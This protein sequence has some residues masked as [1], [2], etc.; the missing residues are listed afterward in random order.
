[1]SVDNTNP[2]NTAAPVA[3]PVETPSTTEETLGT[4]PLVEAATSSEEKKEVEKEIK[5]AIRKLQLKVDGKEV[6]EELPF[7]LPDDPA[8]KEYMIRQLQLSK[9]SHQRANQ[10]STLDKE[11]RSFIQELRTDPEK[12]LSDPAFGVDLKEFAAKIIE[13]EIEQSKKS[14]E[15]VQREQLENELKKLQEERT[16]EKEELQQKQLELLQQQEYERYDR[17]MSDVLSKSDLPKS[18]YVVKKM[19]DYMLL[20]LESGKTDI[21]PSDV[22]PLVRDE[23]HKDIKDMFGIMP[24]EVIEQMIGKDTI[25]KLRKRSVARKDAP[26]PIAKAV[27]DVGHTATKKEA[28]KK[29]SYKEFF[30][31]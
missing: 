28:I 27:T 25:T 13:K 3:E 29:M 31:K 1:M 26:V 12:V 6:T 19:A 14:P 20:A 15:Q 9:M 7:D 11:I 16:K 21:S 30:R 8:V 5:K 10:Y 17:E 24:E 4:V 23:I 22:L 2:T 18:P